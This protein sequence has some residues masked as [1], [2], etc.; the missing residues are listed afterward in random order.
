[1][2]G[3][4]GDADPMDAVDIAD[5]I[6]PV[7]MPY[8]VKV[9]GALG[10]IDDNETDWKV[11]SINTLD[12]LASTVNDITDLDAETIDMLYRWFRDYKTAQGKPQ[13][14]FW[15]GGEAGNVSSDQH[16]VPLNQT[17]DV[18]AHSHQQWQ[19]LVDSCG[20]EGTE[21]EQ[22]SVTGASN[23]PAASCDV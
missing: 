10:M 6:P 15:Q 23:G 8:A 4:I 13:N 14:Q 18:I 3:F 11:V 9:L 2:T 7:G 1:M 17:K 5:A 16:F 12:P 22:F 21:Y 20:K 19:V